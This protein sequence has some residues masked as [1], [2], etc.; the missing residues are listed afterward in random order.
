M[1]H[2]LRAIL[3]A[4]LTAA[5]PGVAVR[6]YLRVEGRTVIVGD[7]GIEAR[8]VVVL[9]AGKAATAMA[10]ATLDALGDHV[11]GGLVVTKRGYEATD[12]ASSL[13]IIVAGHPAPDEGGMEA[14]RG[15]IRLVSGLGAG[16]LLLVL[17]SGGAS[18]LLA[19][20]AGDI[21]LDDL[22][23]L[24]E[25]LLRSGAAIGEVN[26]VRKH[27]STLKGG[28]LARLA[29]P[30]RVVALL[31]SDV[32]GDDPSTIGSGPTVPDPTTLA[33]VAAVLRRYAITPPERVARYLW[34]A[35]ETPKP[36]DPTFER[37]TNLVIRG[38]Q[39]LCEAA[40]AKAREVG[41]APLILS[42]LVTGPAREAAG[43]HAAIAREVLETGRP[44]PAPCALISGGE[45][46][47]AVRG[48]GRG[49]PNQ[50]F[51]LALAVALD[52]VEGWAALVVDTDGTDGPTDAAGGLVSS[53]TAAGIRAAGLDPIAA[54]DANDAHNALQAG[55]AL[56]VTGPT[57]T[58]VNDLRVILIG[59]EHRR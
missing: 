1:E 16:D 10:R 36:G 13:D 24:S 45:V 42:T 2:D 56:L 7:Q 33:D 57:G 26:A 22:S 31:L 29:S 55:G 19:D 47:V 32:V 27:L 3:A 11:D 25:S 58:N 30:A 48:V 23:Q 54:L 35:P 38:G 40:A 20:P 18:A 49:G 8:R 44:L 43:L 39:L 34:S 9:A 14:A 21:A 52:G 6:R 5:D 15:A 50:E 28:G 37:V 59:E 12:T 51:A 46:T 17:L 53:R 41:Y 4:A